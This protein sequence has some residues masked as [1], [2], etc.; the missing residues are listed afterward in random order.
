MDARDD[1]RAGMVAGDEARDVGRDD[2][3]DRKGED[4]DAEQNPRDAADPAQEQD[5][6]S[7][8]NQVVIAPV[9]R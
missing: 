9:T 2:L 5:R 6:G 4:R 1:L 3:S 8:Q 7:H